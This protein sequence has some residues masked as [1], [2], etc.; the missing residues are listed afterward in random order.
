MSVVGIWHV[1][2]SVRDIEASIR[3][4]GDGMGLRLRHRQIQENEYTSQLVGY[5]D[6]RLSMAQFELPD[7]S[8]SRSGHILE[9]IEYQ[10]PR[11]ESIP[12]ENARITS[13]HLALQVEDLDA[14][15]VRLVSHG[16]RFLSPTQEIT[17]GINTG[18]R[19]VYGR[20]PD[21][22]TFELVQPPARP[23]VPSTRSPG[24][25]G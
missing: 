1:G 14:L 17:A 5:P 3:F 23:G 4:W 13:A 8:D 25:A 9:L 10:R 19:A 16:A 15:R 24:E 22:I 6:V 21:D 12:P 2:F 18:G 20:D 7:G 11:G